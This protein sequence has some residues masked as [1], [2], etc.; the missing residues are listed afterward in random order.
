METEQIDLKLCGAIKLGSAIL[1]LDPD[2]II[3]RYGLPPEHQPCLACGKPTSNRKG[4]CSKRCAYKYR[5]V[6]VACEECGRI[7]QKTISQVTWHINN[8]FKHTGKTQQHFF[9][10]V[11]CRRLGIRLVS[12]TRVSKYDHEKIGSLLKEGLSANKIC[13]LLNYK[14]ESISNLC[15]DLRKQLELSVK[16]RREATRKKAK[17]LRASGLK[18]R[19]IASQ[20]DVL[21]GSVGNILKGG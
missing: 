15:V 4:L 2:P 5:R 21:I 13:D 14:R 16:A 11:P 10:S 19:E 3:A 1:K 6:P 17:Q 20:L 9:C 8:P 12:M 7:F 18:Y